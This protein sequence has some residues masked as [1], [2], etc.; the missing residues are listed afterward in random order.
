MLESGKPEPGDLRRFAITDVSYKQETNQ[1]TLAWNSIPDGV[2][3]I[4]AS[5]EPVCC[6]FITFCLGDRVACV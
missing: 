5:V 3:T 1:I 6:N 2:Y 4:E